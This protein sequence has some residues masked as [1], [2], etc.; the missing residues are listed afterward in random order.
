MSASFL[1]KEAKVSPDGWLCLRVLN[2]PMAR[3]FVLDMKKRDYVAELKEAHKKRSLD[4][5]AYFWA[6]AEELAEA[7]KSTKEEIYKAAI[8]NVG[9]FRDFHLPVDEAKSFRVAW[10]ALGTG[11]P[12]EQVDFDGGDMVTI[13]AYYGSSTYST[14]RMSRLID[15]IVQDCKAVGIETLPP[16]KLSAMIAD[17]KPVKMGGKDGE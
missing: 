17:Y 4:A 13:R 15:H 11:W 1:F 9:I 2:K 7:V 14:K 3:Q 16:D 12:T 10:E 8:K 5:N 6:L